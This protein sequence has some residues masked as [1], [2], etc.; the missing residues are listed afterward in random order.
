MFLKHKISSLAVVLPIR[1]P[2]SFQVW[3]VNPID[4][5]LFYSFSL[6][7]II[8]PDNEKNNSESI[9]ALKWAPKVKK[10]I[11]TLEVRRTTF[12][13]LK[14]RTCKKFGGELFYLA[15]ERKCQLQL[16]I[17]SDHTKIYTALTLP[18]VPNVL[19]S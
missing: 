4:E 3:R 18:H 10:N 17:D 2:W 5:I 13:K 15:A 9:L 6:N 14:R 12:R 1:T 19:V 8:D 16:S 7:L 11:K